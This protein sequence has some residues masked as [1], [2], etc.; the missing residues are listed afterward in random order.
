MTTSGPASGS[1]PIVDPMTLTT[2]RS[3]FLASIEAFTSLSGS[4]PNIG[5]RSTSR[6]CF[7]NLCVI[8]VWRRHRDSIRFFPRSTRRWC[9]MGAAAMGRRDEAAVRV[10]EL[11]APEQQQPF[12]CPP[13]CPDGEERGFRHR[14]PQF[15]T[16]EKWAGSLT[17]GSTLSAAICATLPMPS[18]PQRGRDV[19]SRT[20]AARARRCR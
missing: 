4:A 10:R 1:M 20:R 3:P 7:R 5:W 12:Q 9:G 17:R 19:S 13:G 6:L 8:T 14:V 2:F 18:S 16:S 11:A 15:E